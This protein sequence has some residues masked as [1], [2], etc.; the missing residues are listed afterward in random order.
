MKL[1][2]IRTILTPK[3]TVGILS[4][5]GKPFCSVLEDKVRKG[6]DKKVWG[7]TAIPAGTYGVIINQ[8]TR[9]T[10]LKGHPVFLPLLINVPGYEGVRIHPGNKPADTEGCLLVGVYSK[11][12]PD[13]VS[14]SQDTF[15][16]LFPL[17]QAAQDRKEAITITIR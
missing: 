14:Q 8:S 6:T 4:V 2:L 3:S 7:E 13:W 5:D 15:H 9:F 11:D 10:Q 17:L 16:K 12:S 1:T